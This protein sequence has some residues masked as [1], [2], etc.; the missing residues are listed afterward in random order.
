M[1]ECPPVD[2]GNAAAVMDNSHRLFYTMSHN[3]YKNNNMHS[4]CKW[5]LCRK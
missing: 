2:H 3:K 1:C 5:H 4:V